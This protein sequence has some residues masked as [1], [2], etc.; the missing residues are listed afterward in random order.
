MATL[1]PASIQE[2]AIARLAA[3][4]MTNHQIARDLFLSIKTIEHHLG[5]IYTT[6]GVTSPAGLASQLVT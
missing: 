1:G 2:Q 3:T 4:G 6:L 5:R